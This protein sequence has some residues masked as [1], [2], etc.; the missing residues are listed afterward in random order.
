MK[1]L[2]L[3]DGTIPKCKCSSGCYKNGGE[4]RHTSN[5]KYAKIKSN[6]R[7]FKRVQESLFEEEK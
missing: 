2:Y 3:C 5:V 1:H 4:C 6:K 7:I